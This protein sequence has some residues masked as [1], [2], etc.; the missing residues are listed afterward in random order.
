[1]TTD[2]LLKYYGTRTA[3]AAAVH[4][5]SPQAV[6][7]WVENKQIPAGRQFEYHLV[8][9]GDLKVDPKFLSA[10]ANSGDKNAAA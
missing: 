6:A 3:A 10:S 7:Q 8:T 4:K 9:K 1:M 5:C 2:Q